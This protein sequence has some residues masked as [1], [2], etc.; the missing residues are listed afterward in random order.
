MKMPTPQFAIG[1]TVYP[2]LAPT[3]ENARM[4]T[5]YVVRPN[6]I[7]YLTTGVDGEEKDAYECELT[8]ELDYRATE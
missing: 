2:K 6:L 3:T 8:T 5:G 1:T 7:V 4:V